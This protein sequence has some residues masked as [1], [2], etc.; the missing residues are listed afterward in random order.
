[1]KMWTMRKRRMPLNYTFIHIMHG[2]Y[3]SYHCRNS[4]REYKNATNAGCMCAISMHISFAFGV[5]VCVFRTVHV[6]ILSVNYTTRQPV[7]MRVSVPVCA[8]FYI[9]LCFVCKQNDD[10]VFTVNRV[11]S[12]LLPLPEKWIHNEIG[13]LYTIAVAPFH[14]SSYGPGPRLTLLGLSVYVVCALVSHSIEW[15][16]PEWTSA[17]IKS[18]HNGSTEHAHHIRWIWFSTLIDVGA[19]VSACNQFN[20][21]HCVSALCVECVCVCVCAELIWKR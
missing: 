1:M 12:S 18:W 15:N 20:S 19:V 9:R 17:V 16:W 21:S 8:L 10:D 11:D 14:C 13:I 7:T 3:A 4:E 5:C 6:F 2:V